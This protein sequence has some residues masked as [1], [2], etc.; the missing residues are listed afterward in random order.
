MLKKL[1]L[2]STF[3]S[4]T[5]LFSQQIQ[6]MEFSNQ[7]IS[8]ILLVLA[9]SSGHSIIP[10]E[11]VRGSASYY[12]SHMDFETSLLL[13]LSTYKYYFRKE[14][15]IY[16]V[17][18]IRI[19][20]D[21]SNFFI[22]LDAEDTD[23]QLIIRTISK[24][25]GKTILYDALPRD[26]IS[27]HCES[28]SVEAILDIIMRK[29]SDYSLVKDDSFYY[30]RKEI[31]YNS[32]SGSYGGSDLFVEKDGLFSSSFQ[33][34]RYKD[35]LDNLFAVAHRE[36]SFLGRNDSII[37]NFDFSGKNFE[38]ILRLLLEK[39]NGDYK[40]I[41]DI[42]YII[43]IE[44]RDILKKFYST[45][46]EPLKFTSV[47]EMQ[48]LIPSSLSSSQL[49][50]ID[51]IN[52]AFILSGTLEEIAPLQNFIREI[53]KPH[54]GMEY[55]HFSLDYVDVSPII[56]SLPNEMQFNPPIVLTESNSFIMLLPTSMI[57]VV[58]DYLQLIDVEKNPYVLELKYIK[59][60][61][62]LENPPPSANKEN[63]LKSNNPNIL[64]YKG[65]ESSYRSL[66]RD[67]ELLDR[68][69]PQIRYEVLVMQVQ[70]VDKF[71]WDM[72]GSNSMTTASDQTSLL[73]A[74]G[75]LLSL[76]FDIVSQ[77]GYQFA[78]DLN[79][80]MENSESK[81]MADT[82][83]NAL[84]G[85][86]TY[87]QNTETYRYRETEIDPDTG[88]A[89]STGVTREITSGLIVEIDGWTSGDGM[90]TMDVKTTISKRDDTSSTSSSAIP[91]TSER[92]VTT[93]I[94]TESGK[95]VIIGGLMQQDK[96]KSVK[97]T[98]LLGD[99]PLLGYIFRSESET[100]QNTEMVVTIV[101][102]LEYPE[103]SIS[104]VERDMESLYNRYVRR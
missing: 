1:I 79:I 100:L 68:P 64:Y 7:A 98:P 99:I 76:N 46:Y 48:S 74:L 21:E 97:K 103:Y 88:D 72:N 104:D 15:D 81:V 77:F 37:E 60:E 95:P 43:D 57:P 54:K 44:R 51:K 27:L 17:S 20:S 70:E 35:A 2:V 9:Q 86:S 13:F 4:V 31:P 63:L 3:I 56:S 67:L 28:L 96:V 14:E 65:N 73:G 38:Q 42:H 87:F 90:I 41:N 36:Y 93:H 23:I 16:Y 39:G 62:L 66:L 71:N 53:D 83:L 8:D 101:P 80:S 33:Q 58:I 6:S 25:I 11:T 34:A 26:S 75:S 10:D 22:S 40:I 82:S 12:F 59:G 50:K 55:H 47:S 29:Y 84:S 24:Q 85:E 78:L 102:Y 92:S 30:I 45:V 18:K 19:D 61:D 89:L 91:T 94:R 69:V 5:S 52:N 32:S 49:I